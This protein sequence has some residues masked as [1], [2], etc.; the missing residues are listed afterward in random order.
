MGGDTGARS[1]TGRVFYRAGHGYQGHKTTFK[2]TVPGI[3][4]SVY[5]TG[6]VENAAKFEKVMD[7]LARYVS[8]SYRKDG[9]L[10]ERAMELGELPTDEPPDEPTEFLKVKDEKGD[11]IKNTKFKHKT[12]MFTMKLKTWYDTHMDVD[13]ANNKL[14]YSLHGQCS[15]AMLT[16]IEGRKVFKA[17]QETLDGIGILALIRRI[18]C[19][20]EHHVHLTMAI[21][22]AYKNIF[23]LWQKQRQT[24]DD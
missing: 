12:V 8:G 20:V 23:C 9:T 22:L 10:I 18:M 1:D 15:L 11:P 24:N 2:R 21:M 5:V 13:K 19:S 3:V 4:D 14:Y 7:A 16:N 17:A 6:Y